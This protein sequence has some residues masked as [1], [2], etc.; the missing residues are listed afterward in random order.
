MSLK[1]IKATLIFGQ[2]LK[3]GGEKF[4]INKVSF[5][6]Y[7]YKSDRIHI[8]GVKSISELKYYKYMMEN[9]YEQEVIQERIDNMFY[10]KKDDRNI[11]LDKLY[12]YMQNSDVYFVNYNAERFCGMFL[13][14]YNN[15]KCTI[16]MFRTGS[17]TFLGMK[18]MEE[19]EDN[20]KFVNKLILLF[21]YPKTLPKNVNKH[22]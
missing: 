21:Q 9:K 19:I 16:L 17:Y 12:Y 2:D 5:T 13:E 10:S 11:D 7:K 14:P 22:V 8:T 4:K 20:I 1:N 3:S 15:G 6:I 18:T